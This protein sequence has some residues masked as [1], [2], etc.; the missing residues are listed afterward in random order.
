MGQLEGFSLPHGHAPT[1]VEIEFTNICN[2]RCV[3]CPRHDMPDYGYLSGPTLA[4]ILDVYRDYRNDLSGR[5]PKVVLAGGGE[6]LLHRQAISFI[7]QI[8]SAGFRITLITNASR[9]HAV[10]M[11]GLIR[12]GR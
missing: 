3:A 2:A 8:R 7:R 12:I 6:P 10:D 9:F 1:Q 11:D 5:R 4:R